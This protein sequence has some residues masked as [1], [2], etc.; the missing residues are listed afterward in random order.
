MS[1]VIFNDRS[2]FLKIQNWE[3]YEYYA[4]T[5]ASLL[6]PQIPSD[7]NNLLEVQLEYVRTSRYYILSLILTEVTRL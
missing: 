1:N 4:K 3:Q 2:H 5:Q 6:T 7:E